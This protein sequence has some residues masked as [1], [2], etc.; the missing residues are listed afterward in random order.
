MNKPKNPLKQCGR[1]LL[2]DNKSGICQLLNQPI[3]EDTSGCPS[4]SDTTFTCSICHRQILPKDAILYTDS[5]SQSV[6]FT[7]LCPSCAEKSGTCALCKNDTSDCAF[8]TDPSPLPFYIQKRVSQGPM[9]SVIQVVNPERMAITCE[10]GCK[11]YHKET[12]SCAKNFGTCE[13]FD[14]SF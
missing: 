10:K 6:T 9:V 11:C 2:R 5:D 14:F 4:F 7:Y 12:K 1:C 3:K 8:R 13:H